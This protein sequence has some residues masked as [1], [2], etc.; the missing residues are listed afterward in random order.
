MNIQQKVHDAI[1][2]GVTALS[3]RIT[4]GTL[5]QSPV[6]PAA[7]YQFITNPMAMNF[8]QG[9]RYTFFNVQVTLHSRSYAELIA[10]RSATLVA[11]EAMPEYIRRATDM[12]TPYEFKSKTRTWVLV[13]N[14]RDS[15]Q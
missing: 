4:P 9:V 12:E 7:S 11:F 15:E 1:A 5:P 8:T 3:G 6:F 13:F 14:L 10:L 2:A